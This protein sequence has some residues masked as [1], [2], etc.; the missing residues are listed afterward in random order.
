MGDTT[1]KG[2]PYPTGTDKVTDGDNAIQYLA[3]KIDT[4][5]GEKT[6]FPTGTNGTLNADGSVTVDGREIYVYG[7]FVPECRYYR[8]LFSVE[9]VA[10]SSQGNFQFLI[11]TAAHNTSYGFM[12]ANYTTSVQIVQSP[13]GNNAF[14]CW[15]FPAGGG[16]SEMHFANPSIAARK[17]MTVHS[18]GI[19]QSVHVDGNCDSLSIFT[20][21][22][23]TGMGES[24]TYRIRILGIY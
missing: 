22:R 18:N 21:F 17:Y 8:I 4:T 2:F 11:G 9:G 16:M 15:D 7:C 12:R 20:G 5:L 3:E 13:S 14:P 19:G 10:P 23:I 6:I 1:T 24:K